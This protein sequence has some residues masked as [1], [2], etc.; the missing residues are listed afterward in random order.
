MSMTTESDAGTE[1]SVPP[2]TRADVELLLSN[3]E[4]PDKLDL[5]FHQ[6]QFSDL[7]YMDLQGANLRGA[8][9]QG[10]NLRGTNLCD[11]HLQGANLGNADLDGANLS[12]AHLGETEA[13]RVNLRQANL[14]YAMLRELDLRGFD[15]SELDM[16]NADL[17]GTDLR[18]AILRGSDLR[19]AELS[20]ALL[21]GP[22]L[23]GAILFSEKRLGERVKLA[24]RS[25]ITY[26][27]IDSAEPVLGQE[28]SS[29]IKGL[30]VKQHRKI[31][32]DR[33]AYL[34]GEHALLAGS[35]PDKIRQLF[36]HGFNF[37]LAR[38]FFDAWLL[39]SEISYS[40]QE[41]EAMWIGFAHRICDLYHQLETES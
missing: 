17:Y 19:G 16:H 7:S 36:P 32:S 6:L 41:S 14:S 4:G 29:P 35:D 3:V 28:S 25:V 10:A 26:N 12:H 40:G 21:H 34:L 38:Q 31:L 23:L 8:D 33:E 18:D 39:Q 11:A 20:T 22:E 15:L 5:S 37:A 27:R 13:N 24:H 1:E 30:G 2:L 9:L